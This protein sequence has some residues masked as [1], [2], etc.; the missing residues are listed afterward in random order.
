[1][2]RYKKKQIEQVNLGINTGKL[3]ADA[4]VCGVARQDGLQLDD[5]NPI[6]VNTANFLQTRFYIQIDPF[7]D[8]AE[9]CLT[10]IYR[11]NYSG[12]IEQKL[13]NKKFLT[14]FAPSLAEVKSYLNIQPTLFQSM[15]ALSS[16]INGMEQ[17]DFTVL[18]VYG[19][20]FKQTGYAA[21]DNINYLLQI[22]IGARYT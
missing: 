20:Y 8:D 14:T 3:I 12:S 15:P 1:M 16:F 21:Q 9:T 10:H 2:S 17:K 6:C 18:P 22:I 5:D 4:D 19:C 7:N 11:N 13:S